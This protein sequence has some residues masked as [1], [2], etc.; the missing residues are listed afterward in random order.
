MFAN[1][2]NSVTFAAEI[3]FQGPFVYRLGRMVFI[4]VR[5]VRF[6][7]GLLKLPKRNLYFI[8]NL[9]STFRG[10][11]MGSCE[12]IFKISNKQRADRFDVWF[13]RQYKPNVYCQ[14]FFLNAS[15]PITGPIAKHK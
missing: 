12:C 14:V 7:Y 15:K 11:F 5:A 4:H 6:R 1:N 9:E 13:S 10:F 3:K 2:K 8:L